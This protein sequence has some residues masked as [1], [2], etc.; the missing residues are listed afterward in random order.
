MRRRITCSVYA[1]ACAARVRTRRAGRA[2][3]V[4]AERLEGRT[5][6]VGETYAVTGSVFHDVDGNGLRSLEGEYALSARVVY[7]DAN[8]DGV[9]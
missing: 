2:R 1:P 6:L 3:A 4:A 8:R 5:L 9:R 7:A